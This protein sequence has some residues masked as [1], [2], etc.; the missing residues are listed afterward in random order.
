MLNLFQKFSGLK[1]KNQ[2]RFG[3]NKGSI[4]E[5]GDFLKLDKTR[6]PSN[7]F[8]SS[9]QKFNFAPFSSSNIY[10]AK[11]LKN[12]SSLEEKSNDHQ[13]HQNNSNNSHSSSVPPPTK[14]EFKRGKGRKVAFILMSLIVLGLASTGAKLIYD[15]AAQ[16]FWLEEGEE[17]EEKLHSF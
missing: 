13:H 9:T 7:L 4:I 3:S 2:L 11:E 16:H 10:R 12:N 5:K 6:K 14:N 8:E 15:Q 1:S 17:K